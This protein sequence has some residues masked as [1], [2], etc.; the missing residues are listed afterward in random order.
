M[1]RKGEVVN[2][3]SRSKNIN[4]ENGNGLGAYRLGELERRV[5]N[6]EGKLDQINTACIRIEARLENT[7]TSTRL[8]QMFAGTGVLC[9]LTLVSHVVMRY[10]VKAG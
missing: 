6:L 1:P 9:L 10:L 2:I 8:W 3:G 4:G 5:A 7:A